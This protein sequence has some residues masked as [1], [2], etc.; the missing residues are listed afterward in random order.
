MEKINT[1][2]VNGETYS[3]GGG[4]DINDAFYYLPSEV[5][6]L[7]H[8]DA[9]E[10][11]DE[12]LGGNGDKTKLS[13]LMETAKT[14]KIFFIKDSGGGITHVNSFFPTGSGVLYLQFYSINA[15][16]IPKF[17]VVGIMKVLQVISGTIGVYK[18]QERENV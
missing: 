5:L 1:I 14:G 18:L 17:Y 10:K 11:F 9:I 15:Q 12:L 8:N 7:E 6:K 3:I 4:S 2:T 16:S 13:E